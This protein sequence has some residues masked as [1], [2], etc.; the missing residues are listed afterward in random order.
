MS[1]VADSAPVPAVS[2]AGLT[3]SYGGIRALT[4]M[5]LDMAAGSVHAVVGENGG[6]KSTLMRL[7]AGAIDPDSGEIRIGGQVV[8]LRSART[9]ARTVSASSTS[10]SASCPSGRSWP[11]CS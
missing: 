10:S 2:T 9:P 6:G 4:G 7:L 3:R 1:V 8:R 5:D 11:T